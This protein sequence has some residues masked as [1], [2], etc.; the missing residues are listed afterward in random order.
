[1]PPSRLQRY[2]LNL[3]LLILIATFLPLSNAMIL[4]IIVLV[5]T[6]V[7]ATLELLLVV[8]ATTTSY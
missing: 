2:I 4:R 7:V 5:A 8:P 1:M 3:P 6:L